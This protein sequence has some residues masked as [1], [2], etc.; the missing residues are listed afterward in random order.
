MR[1]TWKKVLSLALAG[2]MLISLAACGSSNSSG[3][4]STGSAAATDSSTMNTAVY[5]TYDMPALGMDP[6]SNYNN[7]IVSLANIYDTLLRY[8]YETDECEYV[9]CDSYESSEDGLTWTFHIRE[10]MKFHDGTDVDA[11]A[12]KYSFERTKNMGLGAAFIWD[13]VDS[14]E[15]AE[16]D[17]NTLIMNLSYECAMDLTC[18]SPY[19]AYIMSPT[20]VGDA[21]EEFFDGDVDAGSGPYMI[22]SRT[23]D[24]Q[25]ILAKFDDYWDEWQEGSLDKVVLQQSSESSTRRQM[26][27]SGEADFVSELPV[28]D[29]EALE[30]NDK[31]ATIKT[32]SFE[33]LMILVNSKKGPLADQKVRQA[34][35]YAFPYQ[36]VIDYVIGGNGTQSYGPVPAGL[37]GHS[38]EV[39]QYSYDL[40]KAAELL[41]EAGYEGGGFSLEVTYVTGDETERKIAELYQSELAKIGITLEIS[42][43]TS[44]MYVEKGENSD[45]NE[46]QDLAFMFWYPDVPS[47][48]TFLYSMYHTIDPVS[49]NFSYYN[50]EEFDAR[51]D[52]ANILA[53]TD[54][55]AAAAEFVEAQQEVMEQG[56]SINCYDKVY[57]RAYSSSIQGYADDPSYPN[58]VFFQKCTRAAQ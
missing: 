9:A 25:L 55:D 32:N 56:L 44:D 50:N 48:Y 23:G 10:G 8:N 52:A 13:A 29:M 7:S 28:E 2:T 40:D 47:P 51:I 38:D 42:P 11:E 12:V 33:N 6:S 3:E 49:F 19:G 17:A 24:T 18:C 41:K 43:L 46:C 21:G 16:D 4:D 22:E 57:Y 34:I 27:E 26:L 20:A 15:V 1:I 58:V 54:R 5:A 37:W 39:F 31:V 36:D 30:G 45:P 35:N 53:G 14:F